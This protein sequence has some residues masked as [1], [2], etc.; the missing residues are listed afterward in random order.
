VA[1]GSSNTPPRELDIFVEISIEDTLIHEV[2][3]RADIKQHPAQIVKPQRREHLRSALYCVLDRFAVLT[4]RMFSSGLNLRDDGK[5]VIGGSSWIDR[6]IAALL[7]L[8]ISLLGIATSADVQ[9]ARLS[10]H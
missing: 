7:M 8:E 6:P 3:S 9:P 5:A 10:R 1:G 4:N 2:Q